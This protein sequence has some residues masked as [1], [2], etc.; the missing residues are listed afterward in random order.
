MYNT[1]CIYTR[2]TV[3][4]LLSTM[5][6]GGAYVPMEPSFPQA[7][8]THILQDAQPALIVY[9]DTGKSIKT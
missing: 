4:T 3:M 9:D 5:K 2:S 1:L 6:A 8:V 7:R